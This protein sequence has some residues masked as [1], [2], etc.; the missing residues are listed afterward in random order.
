VRDGHNGAIVPAGDPVALAATLRRFARDGKLRARLG[1]TG[2]A[3]VSAYTHDA[4]T[5]GFSRALAHLGLSRE[6]VR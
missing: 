6:A 1:D 4:W 3:D 5:E 2:R